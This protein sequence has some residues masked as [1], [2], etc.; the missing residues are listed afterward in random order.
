ML[1]DLKLEI[2]DITFF[3]IK[4]LIF[5][6]PFGV[7]NE[8]PIFLFNN[9]IIFDIIIYRKMDKNHI[10]FKIK[11]SKLDIYAIIFNVENNE[12]YKF[13]NNKKINIIGKISINFWKNKFFIQIVILD[14]LFL[15]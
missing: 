15:K 9:L 5:L 11:N 12:I 7:G 2:F 6:S 13:K 3:F 8:N 14:I 1:A 4:Q 10:K